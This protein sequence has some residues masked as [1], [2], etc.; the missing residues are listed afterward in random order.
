MLV[1]KVPNTIVIY[2]VSS[3][4]I[5]VERTGIL[6]TLEH[7]L[8]EKGFEEELKITKDEL[9]KSYFH[10]YGKFCEIFKNEVKDIFIDW[11]LRE[12][13]SI[14]AFILH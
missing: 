5:L 7:A 10:R 13:R 11:N 6:I 14:M 4:V 9:E 12:D 8:I 2:P 1:Q 3:S